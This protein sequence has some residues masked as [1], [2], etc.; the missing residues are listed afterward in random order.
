MFV[1][2][3]K[4]TAHDNNISLYNTVTCIQTNLTQLSSGKQIN[5]ILISVC[6]N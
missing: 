1:L 4:I 5:G 3:Y 6:G 2:N